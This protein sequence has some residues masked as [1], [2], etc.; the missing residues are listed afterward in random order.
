MS[1][2]CDRTDLL[3]E[4][5]AHCRNLVSPEEEAA[6]QRSA[7]VASGKW[8]RAV[9]KGKCARCGE[10]FGEGSAITRRP[11]GWISDCCA[12]AVGDE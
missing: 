6:R 9:H 10:W 2:R 11:S 1:E 8:L 5:C 4:Q 12:D 7:L 3:V